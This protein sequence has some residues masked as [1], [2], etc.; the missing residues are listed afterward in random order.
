MIL[1]RVSLIL[2]L[3]AWATWLW[4]FLAHQARGDRLL[5]GTLYGLTFTAALCLAALS[6]TVLQRHK[7]ARWILIVV[8]MS[9]ALLVPRILMRLEIR[10]RHTDM[11]QDPY[12]NELS[13]HAHTFDDAWGHIH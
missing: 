9:L 1:R 8:L 10:N 5:A 6:F 3:A 13:T 7:I 4:T 11:I 2:L 12:A